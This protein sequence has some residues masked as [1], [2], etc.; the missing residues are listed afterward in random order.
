MQSSYSLPPSLPPP[1]PSSLP[2]HL[3]GGVNGNGKADPVRV[4]ELHAVDA[5]HFPIQVHDGAAC[6][7]VF[8]GGGGR[9]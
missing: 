4:L 9:N 3:I 8:F 2:A 6:I 5:H 1:L 7:Y